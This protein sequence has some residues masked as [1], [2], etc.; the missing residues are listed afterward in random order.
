MDQPILIQKIEALLIYGYAAVQ[1]FPKSERHALSQQLRNIMWLEL[2]CAA[3]AAS[4]YISDRA[5][6]GALKELDRHNSNLKLQIRMAHKLGFLSIKK[7]ELWVG[8]AVEV[9]KIAGSWIK[10]L[11]G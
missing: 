8:H 10:N 1:H 3:H 4:P 9:G 11:Q 7:Y 2:E 6:L 5:K